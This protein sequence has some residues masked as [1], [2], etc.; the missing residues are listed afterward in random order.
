MLYN[1]QLALNTDWRE[2][3]LKTIYKKIYGKQKVLNN[4]WV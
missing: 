3:Y 2:K 1:Q 4:I